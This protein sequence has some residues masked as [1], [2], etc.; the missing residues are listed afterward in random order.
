MPSG[1]TK[2]PQLER[3]LNDQGTRASSAERIPTEIKTFL[4][5]FQ[6]LDI[7]VQKAH[8]QT[9]LK[10]AYIHRDRKIEVEFRG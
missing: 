9:I 2:V 6:G 10:A 8:L 5:D 4:E 1:T 7:R 3:W